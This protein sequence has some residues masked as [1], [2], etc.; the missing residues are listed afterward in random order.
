MTTSP[1]ALLIRFPGTNCDAETA[2]ALREAG[3]GT[4]TEPVSLLSRKSLEGV[5]LENNNGEACG[6]T[7]VL[8]F[9]GEGGGEGEGHTRGRNGGGCGRR[10]GARD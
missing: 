4:R 6:G 9:R 8:R 5:R 1:E 3:F 2:R 10:I 7:V